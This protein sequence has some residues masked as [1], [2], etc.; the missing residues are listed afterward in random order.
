MKT[1][2]NSLRVKDLIEV[3][4]IKDANIA[5]LI[6]DAY[7]RGFQEGTRFTKEEIIEKLKED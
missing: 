2:F 4:K 5:Q 3:S 7:N 6:V 1:S